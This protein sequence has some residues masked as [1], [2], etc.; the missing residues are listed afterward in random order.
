MV[1]LPDTQNSLD[2]YF[3]RHGLAGQHGDPKYKDDSLRPLT[4]QG[5]IKMQRVALGMQALGL[6]F[7]VV[8]SSPY[9]RALQ[10]AETVIQVYKLKR[11]ILHLTDNLLPPASIEKL[12]Q[13]VQKVVTGTTFSRKNKKPC[14]SL[15][16]V[17]HEPHL[18]E[19][20]SDLMKSEKHLPIDLKKGGLCCL[21]ISPPLIKGTSAAFNWLLT[22]TQ[23]GLMAKEKE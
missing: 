21:S 23:L 5:R 10:T 14:L 17:G 8:F 1:F 2:L 20:I 13:E 18:T 7:D 22:S 16:F 19:M 6:K 4:E 9:L 15:L 11:K 3:L 12:L